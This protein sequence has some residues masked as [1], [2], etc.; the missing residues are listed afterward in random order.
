MSDGSDEAS[1]PTKEE[2]LKK[3]GAPIHRPIKTPEPPRRGTFR[4]EFIP[5]FAAVLTGIG[6]G[7]LYL[8]KRGPEKSYP[9]RFEEI[10]QLILENKHEEVF[11]KSLELYYQKEANGL[12]WGGLSEARG[13]KLKRESNRFDKSPERESITYKYLESSQDSE[14]PVIRVDLIFNHS[15]GKLEV[16][17]T[18]ISLKDL[19]Y[20]GNDFSIGRNSANQTIGLLN[21][22]L[23][24]CPRAE[25]WLPE[26]V[27]QAGL[28]S[29][30]AT[31]KKELIP[32]SSREWKREFVLRV[33]AFLTARGFDP[34]V[35][36]YAV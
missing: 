7:G 18:T 21:P 5:G 16:N 4:R 26:N 19:G 6:L 10:E 28:Q 33:D 20:V 32:N 31:S 9:N 14:R 12:L 25:E 24:N 11:K 17:S 8:A 29:I 36:P 23:I 13:N 30:R 27:T 34:A 22:L 35:P 1:K 15:T 2:L 3:H